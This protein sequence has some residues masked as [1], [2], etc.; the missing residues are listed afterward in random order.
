M[1]KIGDYVKVISCIKDTYWY[2]NKIGTIYKIT[3]LTSFDGGK[4]EPGV[5]DRE[6][7]IPSYFDESDIVKVKRK[8]SELSVWRNE[9]PHLQSY[10]DEVLKQE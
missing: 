8:P 2:S 1:V 10:I 3:R 4:P 6:D 5:I 7:G 9:F